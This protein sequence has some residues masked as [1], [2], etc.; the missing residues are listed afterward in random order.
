MKRWLEQLCGPLDGQLVLAVG[1]YLLGYYGLKA[2]HE[3]LEHN[4]LHAEINAF[5]EETRR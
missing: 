2:L 5:L 1:Y 3:H 4:L